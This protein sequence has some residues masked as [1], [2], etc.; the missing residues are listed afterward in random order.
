MFGKTAGVALAVVAVLCLVAPTSAVFKMAVSQDAMDRC[1]RGVR[2]WRP[3]CGEYANIPNRAEREALREAYSLRVKRQGDGPPDCSTAPDPDLCEGCMDGSITDCPEGPPDGEGG[4]GGPPDVVPEVDFPTL[5]DGCLTYE[6]GN[7]MNK[8][9]NWGSCMNM[10]TDDTYRYI[11]SNSVPDYYVN[12][13]CPLGLGFGYCTDAEIEAGT[14]YFTTLIC[15][16][17]NG[18]GSNAYGDVWVPAEDN[19]MIPLKGNPTLEDVPRDMYDS[20]G[21]GAYKTNGAATGVATNGI[22]IL[23]PN[24]AGDV[25]IDQAGLQLP[26]GG[27]VTPPMGNLDTTNG[28]SGPP[29]YHLHKSPECLP[30]FRNASEGYYNAGAVIYKHAQLMGWAVD[31]FGIYAYNDVEGKAPV[32]DECGGHFGP[33]DTG[34]VV[35]HYH[36]RAI[37]PYHLACQGPS[38]GG[39]AATQSGVNYCHPG[40][41]FDVCVQPGTKESELRAYLADFDDEWLDKYTVNDYSGAVQNTSNL[42]LAAM[43]A[44]LVKYLLA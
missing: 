37:V 23:G 38:L 18:E 8:T 40:C 12:S 4:E 14:C 15:G 43:A 28:P 31:G 21:A 9:N 35:Y 20:N 17:E 13:Y 22:G 26:C 1:H 41:G 6:W 29:K 3:R 11:T 24:D 33:V 39:C 7:H 44:C 32:V 2:D 36:S 19:Y 42:F 30:A 16:E 10:T 5:A 34:E 27:H 25:S